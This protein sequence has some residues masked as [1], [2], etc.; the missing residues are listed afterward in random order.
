MDLN[1]I[2]KI[3]IATKLMLGFLLIVVITS[4][5]FSVVGVQLIGDRIVSEAQDRV[6]TDLNSA[7]EIYLSQL[8]HVNDVV[9]F[10]ADRFFLKDA[11]LSG[12]IK[13]AADELIKVKERER[14]DVLTITDKSGKVLFR[15]S[16]PKLFGDDQSHDELVRA[17]I[18][19]IEPFKSTSIIPVNDLRK[20]SPLLAERAYFKFIHTPKERVRKETEETAG[21]ML[22]AAVP[23]LDYQNNLIGIIYGGVLLNRNFEIVDKIKQTVFQNVVYEGKD[24]GTATIFLDDIRVSTNVKNKDGLRAIGTRAA[25]DVYNQVVKEGKPWTGRAFV[26]T[27]WY[28]TAYEPIRNVNNKIIGILYV[29]ILEQKYVDIKSRTIVVFLAITLTGALVSMTLSYFISQKISGSVRKLVA[30]SKEVAHGNLDTKV[31]IRTKDELRELADSFNLMASALKKR[32]EKLKEFTK[33]KIMESERL[34]IIG[35]LAADVAHEINNPLQGIVAYSHLLLEKMPG[36]NSSWESIPLG[37]ESIK[38]IVTQANRCTDIIRG[39][40]DFSRQRKPHKKPSN[41][42][43][44]LQECVSLVENQAVFHNIQIIRDF[45]ENLPPVVIDHSQIQQVFMN[46]IINAAEAMDGSGQ[47]TLATRLEPARGEASP[48]LQGGQGEPVEEF[49]EVEFTDTGHG[50]SEG[51]LERI[52]DPFFTTKEMGHGTGLGLAISYGIIK[53]HEGTISVQSEVGKG[54]TFVVRLPVTTEERA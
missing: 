17:V 53:E 3:P 36:E 50:I 49:I 22:K 38:K 32:D 42:N 40:L 5:V 26:V 10:T 21:M 20:E 28:I 9:R 39:L 13:Q 47:L 7:R 54:T 45:K 27:E 24:I 48:A 52:F 14:L 6:R 37:K 34:A 15:T 30:A 41:V 18:E 31:E 1:F 11:L 12:K 33:K 2:K 19:R 4:A 16:N 29:G 46:M 51:N 44:I 8:N 25:E 23:I 43:L 35:Q